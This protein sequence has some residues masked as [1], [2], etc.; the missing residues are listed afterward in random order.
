MTALLDQLL[1]EALAEAKE[2][3]GSRAVVEVTLR[4][5]GDE[6]EG[7]W[8]VGVRGPDAW[9]WLEAGT[10]RTI[11]EALDSIDETGNVPLNP[12]QRARQRRK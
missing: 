9:S 10:G 6:R 4:A 12:T 7:N 5:Y 2:Q 8:S 3:L 1:D 11:R